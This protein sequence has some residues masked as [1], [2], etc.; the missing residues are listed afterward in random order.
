MSKTQTKM[1]L[2]DTS[3]STEFKKTRMK[4]V[5]AMVSTAL[6]QNQRIDLMEFTGT[7]IPRVMVA[8]QDEVMDARGRHAKA[9][10]HIATMKDEVALIM[11]LLQ[12]TIEGQGYLVQR[13]SEENEDLTTQISVERSAAE[14]VIQGINSDRITQAREIEGLKTAL[15]GVLR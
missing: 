3:E 15:K 1:E 14:D 10:K 9:T 13:L 2:V 11:P 12:F 4:E 6:R 8:L 5:R 7:D